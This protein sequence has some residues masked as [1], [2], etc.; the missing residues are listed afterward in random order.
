MASYYQDE[1][2]GDMAGAGFDRRNMFQR[3]IKERVA[4]RDEVRADQ[5]KT[6]YEKFGPDLRMTVSNALLMTNMPFAQ[7]SMRKKKSG[8]AVTRLWE[9]FRQRLEDFISDRKVQLFIVGLIA[10]NSLLMGLTTF[11]D[12][13]DNDQAMTIIGEI[14]RIILIIFTVELCVNLIVHNTKFF[15][16]VGLAF[17]FVTIVT[18]LAFPNTTIIRALRIFRAFRLFGRLDSLK[19][20]LYMLFSTSDLMFSIFFV[21]VLVYYIFAVLFT[22]LLQDCQ[23]KYECYGDED[24]DYFGSLDMSFLSLFQLM[25]L[26]DWAN[27]TRMTQKKFVW[28]WL[29]ILIFIVISSFI[30]LNLIIAVLCDS[31]NNL[32]KNAVESVET[33]EALADAKQAKK[34]CQEKLQQND[35][36]RRKELDRLAIRM[37]DMRKE[38][39][40]VRERK[41]IHR[42]EQRKKSPYSVRTPSSLSS[43]TT[44]ATSQASLTLM[45][46][47]DEVQDW[48]L[49]ES[50][51]VAP[52]FF[53]DSVD[54]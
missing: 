23:E 8:Q 54:W 26:E 45:S 18:S 34:L 36:R 53:R 27:L 4:A 47:V 37:D 39:I 25:V 52:S 1:H 51:P 44:V 6:S 15:A 17:D 33:Q 5:N 30:F 11:K 29:P 32:S 3:T 21:L 38:L 10:V 35:V 50:F 46:T 40:K 16:I 14:D 7:G 42:L 49:V 43:Y 22:Q 2:D 41:R 31:L 13:S 9:G 12:V 24:I 48:N 19:K 28:S 20:I